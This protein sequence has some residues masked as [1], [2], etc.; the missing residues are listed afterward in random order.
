[1]KIQE[2]RMYYRETLS[3]L[4]EKRTRLQKKAAETAENKPLHADRIEIG[5][6][7]LEQDCEKV[8]GYLSALEEHRSNLLNMENGQKQAE[9]EA[10]KNEEML[11]CLEI[12]RRIAKGDKV[13]GG[14]EKKLLEYSHEL[15][16]AAK[17]MAALAERAGKK[18]KSL[19]EDEKP[20]KERDI[21]AEIGEQESPIAE[22]VLSDTGAEIAEE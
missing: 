13:P 5:I 1:M 2:A 19:F 21:E 22:P 11:K 3:R 9:A 16:M 12:F 15:Y 17:N 4:E 18:Q 8:R 14:D 7:A 6:K 10:K 20:E